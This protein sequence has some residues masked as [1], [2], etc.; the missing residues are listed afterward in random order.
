[1]AGNLKKKHEDMKILDISE[2]GLINGITF[3]V[4][5]KWNRIKNIDS[6]DLF[7]GRKRKV[8]P[9]GSVSKESSCNARDLGWEDPLEK[10]IITYFSI[11]AW[12]IPW[13]V[14]RGGLPSMGLQKLDTM[15]W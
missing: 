12:K 11:L 10:E 4:M 6:A 3:Q 14:E 13:T 8:F 7:L 1:M 15:T 2:R 5:M 9:G